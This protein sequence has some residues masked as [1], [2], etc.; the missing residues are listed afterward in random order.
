ME[1]D[2]KRK[3]KHVVHKTTQRGL[4]LLILPITIAPPPSQAWEFTRDFFIHISKWLIVNFSSNSNF[5]HQAPFI[6]RL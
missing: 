6:Y 5:I 1:Q 3:K 2:E 4:K